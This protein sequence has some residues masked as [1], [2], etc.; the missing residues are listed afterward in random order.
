MSVLLKTKLEV[1]LK[2]TSASLDVSGFHEEIARAFL[3]IGSCD[4]MELPSPACAICDGRAFVSQPLKGSARFFLIKC[5][6]KSSSAPNITIEALIYADEEDPKPEV[7]VREFCGRTRKAGAQTDKLSIQVQQEFYVYPLIDGVPALPDGSPFYFVAKREPKFTSEKIRNGVL[8]ILTGV[9]CYA[10]G[11][12]LQ[13]NHLNEI[14]SGIL[15]NLVAGAAVGVGI[16]QFYE[17]LTGKEAVSISLDDA[18]SREAE[19]MKSSRTA[20]TIAEYEGQTPKLS[21]S[22]KAKNYER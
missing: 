8:A 14:L 12:L 2:D 18:V 17:L 22:R 10:I 11:F 6:E 4:D 3:A 7:C 1:L 13:A 20:T 21:H 15:L 16:T 5:K 9:A 19:R